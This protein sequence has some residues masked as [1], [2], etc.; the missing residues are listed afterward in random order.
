VKKLKFEFTGLGKKKAVFPAGERIIFYGDSKLIIA[1]TDGIL[2]VIDLEVCE[3]IKTFDEHTKQENFQ[4]IVHL[5]IA[6]EWL[7]S[8]DLNKNIHVYNLKSL[9]CY[10]TLP[11]FDKQFS[12]FNILIHKKRDP[13]IVVALVSNIFWIYNLTS[14][15]I[16]EW[17]TNY[18]DNI[19]KGLLKRKDKIIGISSNPSNP[20]SIL[21]YGFT[22]IFTIDV[23]KNSYRMT[24]RYQ[25][26]I[27]LE[28]M[29]ENTLLI[30]ERPWFKIYQQ[31]PPPFYRH[32]YADS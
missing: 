12:T 22:F 19:P 1:G 32:R 5:V 26:I 20:S 8:G 11:H 14:Q 3:I 17:S 24:N 23:M 15:K 4:P 29:E 6:K 25:P 9:E 28:Y 13:I 2:Y 27:Y 31:L 18:V 10:T 30:V 21:F 16:S 7:A